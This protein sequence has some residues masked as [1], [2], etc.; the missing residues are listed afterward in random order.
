MNG[1]LTPDGE[2]IP[3]KPYQHDNTARDHGGSEVKWERCGYVKIF[4]DKW[5]CDRFMTDAQEK[6]LIDNNMAESE[7]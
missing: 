7:E 6:W 4:N 3:C 1:W 2:Y 5:Y